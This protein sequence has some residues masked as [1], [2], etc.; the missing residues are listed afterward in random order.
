MNSGDTAFDWKTLAW[1]RFNY[2][3]DTGEY[4]VYLVH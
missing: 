2:V 4:L 3:R 1:I